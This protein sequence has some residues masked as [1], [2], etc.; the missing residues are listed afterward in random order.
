MR[1]SPALGSRELDD[2]A[3][4]RLPCSCT[5]RICR[6]SNASTAVHRAPST[7]AKLT[8]FGVG[9]H[10]T[11]RALA[12]SSLSSDR[13]TPGNRLSA[14][15]AACSLP[16]RRCHRQIRSGLDVRCQP[17]NLI[18]VDLEPAGPDEAQ[19]IRVD[20]HSRPFVGI[21]REAVHAGERRQIGLTSTSVTG[22]DHDPHIRGCRHRT[23][24]RS[25]GT[26]GI[27]LPLLAAAHASRSSRPRS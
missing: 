2:L 20:R 23:N 4:Q 5:R 13:A 18:D 17:E 21:A 8:T 14:V 9:D 7:T 25:G 1:G 26:Q 15:G 22:V 27:S 10:L 16:K 24:Q 12:R 11:S 19:A 3:L 6:S